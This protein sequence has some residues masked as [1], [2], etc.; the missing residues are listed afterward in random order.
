MWPNARISRGAQWRRILLFTLAK[1]ATLRPVGCIMLLGS[2]AVTDEVAPVVSVP[3]IAQRSRDANT[4]QRLEQGHQG[5]A[6]FAAVGS[7]AGAL[8]FLAAHARRRD[9]MTET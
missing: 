2:S 7:N 8:P 6:A 5:R 1:C 3:P 9:L 4:E